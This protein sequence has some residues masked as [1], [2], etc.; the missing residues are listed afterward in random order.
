[1]ADRVGG[2]LALSRRVQADILSESEPPTQD[3]ES[4]T[5]PSSH[6]DALEVRLPP[7]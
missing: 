3:T 2:W 5:G 1:M 6:D 7:A 4:I